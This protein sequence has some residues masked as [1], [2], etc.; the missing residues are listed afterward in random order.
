MKNPYKNY[1]ILVSPI[2]PENSRERRFPKDVRAR[3]VSEAEKRAGRILSGSR[4]LYRV[5]EIPVG[6]IS[7]ADL[8]GSKEPQ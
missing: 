2:C 8:K 4:L 5:V 6:G 1:A 3:S 7:I